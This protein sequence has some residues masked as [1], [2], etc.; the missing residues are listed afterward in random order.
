MYF[1]IICFI[2]LTSFLIGCSTSETVLN[3]PYSEYVEER[4]YCYSAS[5]VATWNPYRIAKTGNKKY[6]TEGAFPGR[7]TFFTQSG[8]NKAKEK[9]QNCL[10][11]KSNNLCKRV[12]N[13]K[14]INLNWP[15]SNKTWSNF[16]VLALSFD[17][18]LSNKEKNNQ[19]KEEKNN[20]QELENLYQEAC[21]SSYNKLKKSKQKK[22]SLGSSLYLNYRVCLIDKN[23]KIR[24]QIVLITRDIKALDSRSWGNSSWS[25]YE[26]QNEKKYISS[27]YYT[28][29]NKLYL[30]CS[31]KVYEI[32]RKKNQSILES[33]IQNIIKKFPKSKKY[34]RSEYESFNGQYR[35]YKNIER[36]ERSID[37]LEDYFWWADWQCAAKNIYYQDRYRVY[38]NCL[39]SLKIQD[40]EEKAREIAKK[41]KEKKERQKAERKLAE[42]EPY[43]KKC[44]SFG[45]K[46]KSTEISM[47]IMRI[48][49]LE[50]QQMEYEKQIAEAKKETAILYQMIEELRAT[51]TS[52]L[53]EQKRQNYLAQLQ[54][55]T[56]RKTQAIQQRQLNISQ[57]QES[58]RLMGLGLGMMTAN[59]PIRITCNPYLL[60]SVSCTY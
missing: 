44:E 30:D 54:S 34:C 16:A 36:Q 32:A 41:A 35:C 23:E 58:M 5:L 47:C 24:K 59:Q 9:M 27:L 56:L 10:K 55:Q 3:N 50:I 28:L 22:Y 2:L 45:F 20:I 15:K 11:E 12:H 21:I 1:K 48:Q 37:E 38:H 46:R 14:A 6:L 43:K 17:C 7:H 49:E 60:N 31:K 26:C 33:D 4:D 8:Y 42:L 19:I 57:F 53:E 52:I 29:Y 18:G 39:K 25:T 51:N 40:E 13:S